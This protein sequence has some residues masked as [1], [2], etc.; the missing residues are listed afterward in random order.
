MI[1]EPFP[2]DCDD[3]GYGRKSNDGPSKRMH[4]G[5]HLAREQDSGNRTTDASRK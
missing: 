4:V 5:C 2:G 1:A 3:Q